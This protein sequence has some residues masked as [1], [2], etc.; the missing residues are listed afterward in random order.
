MPETDRFDCKLCQRSSTLGYMVFCAVCREWYHYQCVGVTPAI[1]NESWMCARCAALPSSSRIGE[2]SEND[3]VFPATNVNVSSTMTTNPQLAAAP[4]SSVVTIATN[5]GFTLAGTAAFSTAS[6]TVPPGLVPPTVTGPS[7]QVPATMISTATIY[8]QQGRARCHQWSGIE[9]LS[10]EFPLARFLQVSVLQ[11]HLLLC[12]GTSHQE[13]S[14]STNQYFQNLYTAEETHA[15][16]EQEFLSDQIIPDGDEPN[17]ASMSEITTS[18]IWTAIK[19]SAPNKSPGP[20]GIPREFYLRTF[21]VIHREMNLILNEALAGNFP[22]E[23][24]DGVIVLVKN[25]GAGDTVSA[26][27]PISLLNVDYKI[28]SRVLKSR[29]EIVMRAHRVLGEAQKCGNTD[30][31]IFQ[32]TLAIKDRIAQMIHRKQRGKLISFDLEHAFDRVSRRFLSKTMISLGFNGQLVTLLENIAARSSSRILI[33]GKLSQPFPIQRSVRQGDPLSMCL[34][35]IYLHPLLCRLERVC[36]TDLIVAYADDISV[37]V[38]SSEKVERMM[39]LFRRFGRAGGAKLNLMKTTAIDVG[40][41]DEG[42]LVVPFLTTVEKV[43]ILGVF[44]ANSIRLMIKLN[45]EAVIASF[46]RLIW[47]HSLRALALHQKVAVLNTYITSKIWYLSSILPAY[48]I[49]IAKI[50]AIMGNFLWSRVPARVPMQQLARNRE[51]GGLKLQLPALKSKALLINRHLR[52]KECMPYYRSYMDRVNPTPVRIPADFQCLKQVY[53]HLSSLPHHILQNPCIVSIH[54]VFVKQTDVPRIMQKFPAHNWRRIWQNVNDSKI[55][56]KTRSDLYLIV[57]EKVV[58]KKLMFVLGRSDN[59]NCEHCGAMV[60]TI[61]HKYS[62]CQR[63]S[64]AWS[65]FQRRIMATAGGWRRLSIDE[66]LRPTLNGISRRNRK[67]ILELF[68]FTFLL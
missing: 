37:L 27:R 24:V 17:T 67:L 35:V 46:S 12:T 44:Y 66:L 55:P 36:G 40:F 38:T 19:T 32:A 53:Q 49:H 34:F 48:S 56:V 54:D 15:E 43:K 21:D 25:K 65:H 26:Y 1:A 8:G 6:S 39:T 33:N 9:Q 10:T 31:N 14:L 5:S 18:E 3:L 16:A 20:D 57:N 64:G 51:D 23:F 2:L 45:W 52:E 4:N 30:R 11:R 50:T 13:G 42:T 62:D 41:I 68:A 22:S 7:G 60:E 47:L 29:L 59:E 28:L 61:Q 63:I 58:T